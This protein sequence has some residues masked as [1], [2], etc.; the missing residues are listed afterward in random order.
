MQHESCLKHLRYRQ[1]CKGTYVE[2]KDSYLGTDGVK[3]I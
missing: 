2:K 3:D 1:F